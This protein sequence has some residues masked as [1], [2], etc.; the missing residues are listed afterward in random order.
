MPGVAE[1]TGLPGESGMAGGNESTVDRDTPQAGFEEG[2]EMPCD[3]EYLW[4]CSIRSASTMG[5]NGIAI[6]SGA[7]ATVCGFGWLR[8]KNVMFQWI[9]RLVLDPF[10]LA[11][12]G[13]VV[14]LDLFVWGFGL[15]ATS[16][17][18]RSKKGYFLDSDV[19]RAGISLLVS[20]DS[21]RKM[22][23]SVCFRGI[24]CGPLPSV[25]FD[26]L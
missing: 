25:Q 2:G 22:S 23:A 17:R 7:T 5:E 18:R 21:L 10:A 24:F 8:K 4:V 16:R 1:E 13:A 6:D 11:M 20:R 14:S 26:Y 15:F 9:Y 19:V 12:G 3:Q